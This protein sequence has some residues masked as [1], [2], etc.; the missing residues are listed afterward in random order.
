MADKNIQMTQRNTANND[1]D[2]LF[3]N[4][5]AANVAVQTIS[6]LTGNNVQTVLQNLF[7]FANDGK[8]AVA[9]AVTAK[10]VSASPA[11]TFAALATKIGQISTGKKWASGNVSFS[12][13]SLTDYILS[14]NLG[15]IPSF[16]K[17]RYSNTEGSFYQSYRINYTSVGGTTQAHNDGTGGSSNRLDINPFDGTNKLM[18]KTGLYSGNYTVKWE[19]YE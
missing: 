13:A 9:S 15:F 7:Q 6:G 10:G 2:N 3:P 14:A 4:T 12:S 16:V 11:D 5:K 1:W 8:T 17:M 18:V 19:A